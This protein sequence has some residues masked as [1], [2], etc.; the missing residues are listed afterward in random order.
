MLIVEAVSMFFVIYG[1]LKYVT[2][3][4]LLC[5]GLLWN[6]YIIGV[7]VCIWCVVW[8]Y[9]EWGIF[10]IFLCTDRDMIR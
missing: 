6:L 9:E 1:N 5:C 8:V 10:E 4:L 2:F 3:I 7:F